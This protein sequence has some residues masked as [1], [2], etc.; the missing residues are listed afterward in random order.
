MTCAARA[1]S[2]AKAASGSH[3]RARQWVQGLLEMQQ[4]GGDSLDFLE[5]VKVDLFPDEVYVFTPAGEIMRL[6]GG[7]TP[8]SVPILPCDTWNATSAFRSTSLRPSP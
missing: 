1:I 4:A 6:P 3:A 2:E 5:N 7:A 8:V